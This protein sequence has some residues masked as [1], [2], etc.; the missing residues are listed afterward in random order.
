[1]TPTHSPRS[2]WRGAPRLPAGIALIL[3]CL[4]GMV[5]I[6][7][8]SGV[9]SA[10]IRDEMRD[11]LIPLE[12]TL[13]RLHRDAV[14]MASD[15]RGYLLTGDRSFLSTFENAEREAAVDLRRVK[16]LAARAEPSIPPELSAAERAYTTWLAGARRLIA[17]EG[18]EE[19]G[20]EPPSLLAENARTLREFTV[21]MDRLHGLAR[22]R[23]DELREGLAAF[24]NLESFLVLILGSLAAIVV[25]YLAWLAFALMRA[26]RSA[27]ADR[28]QLEAVLA[29]VD[30]GIVL[31]DR[32]LRVRV[33]NERAQ[34]LL[35]IPLRQLAGSDQRR[36]LSERL[37][38]RTADP[39]G[40]ER[41]LAH[42]YDNPEAVAEDIV[43]V[44]LPE[45]L[46]LSRYSAPVRDEAGA[47][48]GRIEVYRDVSELMRRER[49]LAEANE[50]KD[51]FLAT[52]SH[53]LRTPL[54][55]IFGWVELLKEERDPARIAQGLATIQRNVRLQAQLVG[56][57][58][59][60]SRVVNEKLELDLRAVS[61]ASAVEAAVDT[62]RHLADAKEVE[63][64]TRLDS[65]PRAVLADETRFIQILWNLLSNAIKFS[66][67]GGKVILEAGTEG[68]R[69]RVVVEDHGEGI[70]PESLERIFK[71]FEQLSDRRKGGR[72]GLGI[73]LALTRSLVNL[74][75]GAIAAESE[76]PGRGS[77]FTFSI[78]RA[79]PAA[80]GLPGEGED[81]RRPEAR[82]VGAMDGWAGG[83]AVAAAAQV[84]DGGAET[85]VP[86]GLSSDRRP[87]ARRRILVV[88]DNP[89]TLE[90]MRILL[91]SWNYE[92][93]A[94]PDAASALAAIEGEAPGVV[95]SDIGMPHMDGL[96]FAREV[97]GLE[98]AREGGARSVLVA[99]TGFASEADRQR[100]LTA[101]FDAYL[102]K[103]V[104]FESLK[105]LLE[106]LAPALEALST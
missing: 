75:G 32:G 3:L 73:G 29:S 84:A 42:L 97:R 18:E 74:H 79:L 104:D 33:A 7:H 31:L 81:G 52:L 105:V 23:E 57:L 106:R 95:I 59:D 94:A 72:G 53:E 44:T 21:R 46:T 37:K 26:Q 27:I 101:G 80:L 30:S 35:D 67:R 38:P 69:L 90:A 36:I 96:A 61:V 62:V 2:S 93:T 88:E 76:G 39:E 9:R 24:Q 5:A 8:W 14:G 43:E 92:V 54:T 103:P 60:L 102:T 50:R 47:V 68:D 100:A 99:I 6:P 71:P 22:A 19:P 1:M 87:D 98:A 13:E 89:D 66:P 12:I 78:P 25:A 40:F 48:F 82:P 51:R 41:R 45:P 56:D 28:D 63:I 15:M 55:P 49:E 16:E 20:A 65:A 58:L 34:E 85:R 91:A 77:R 64:G 10:E 86:E 11:T 17:L 83:A 4:F 70:A